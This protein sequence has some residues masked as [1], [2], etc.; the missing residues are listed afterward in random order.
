MEAQIA[1]PNHRFNP[2]FDGLLLRARKHERRGSQTT[3]FT[4][5][6]SH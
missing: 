3:P 2:T 4:L 5:W 1:G 6:F